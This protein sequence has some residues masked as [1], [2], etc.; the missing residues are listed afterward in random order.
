M[1]CIIDHSENNHVVCR[2]YFIILFFKEKSFVLSAQVKIIFAIK[3]N[4]MS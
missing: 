2:L 3:E 1:L 4:E